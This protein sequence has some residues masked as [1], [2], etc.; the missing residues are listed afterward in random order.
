MPPATGNERFES[1]SEKFLY[2]DVRLVNESVPDLITVPF[3]V[4]CPSF[5]ALAVSA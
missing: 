3:G 1:V 4:L 5:G 2:P